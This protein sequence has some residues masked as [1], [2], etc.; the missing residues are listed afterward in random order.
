MAMGNSPRPGDP[1]HPG[2]LGWR[3][4]PI[5]NPVGDLRHLHGALLHALLL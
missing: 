1:Q 2:R 4:A 3:E 5:L